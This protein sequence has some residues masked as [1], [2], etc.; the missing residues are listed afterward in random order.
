MT[1]KYENVFSEIQTINSGEELFYGEDYLKI[2]V[3]IDDNIPLNKKVK[4]A[5]LTRIIRCVFQ[6]GKKMYP[7]IY[8]NEYL[9][10]SLKNWHYYYYYYYGD[11]DD[12]HNQNENESE[13]ENEN[14]NVN[15]NE[16]KY[17]SI[18]HIKITN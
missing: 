4:F 6:N 1:E 12:D 8:L 13:I 2:G 11:D 18:S 5:S 17:Y 14:G 15:V 10:Q 3:N 7:Q 16:K 9:Y